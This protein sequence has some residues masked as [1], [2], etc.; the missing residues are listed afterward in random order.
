MRIAI[1]DAVYRKSLEA[2]GELKRGVK[3]MEV[4]KA[5]LAGKIPQGE[6]VLS[7][8]RDKSGNLSAVTGAFVAEDAN[9]PDEFRR[10]PR[11]K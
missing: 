4:L 5:Y 3:Q 1:P 8:E 2:R 11:V 9:I 6:E 10:K 7:Y